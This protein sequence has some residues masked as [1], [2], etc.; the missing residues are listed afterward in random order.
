MEKDREFG[1]AYWSHLVSPINV[2]ATLRILG[3]VG[4]WSSVT[5]PNTSS[6]TCWAFGADT[7]EALGEEIGSR[8]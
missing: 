6:S 3:L 4:G 2:F 7:G 5:P 1:D 8:A